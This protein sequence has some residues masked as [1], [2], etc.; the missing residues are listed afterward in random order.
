M[1]RSNLCTVQA[2]RRSPLGRIARVL[3]CAAMCAVLTV[4]CGG[5]STPLE[6]L[7]AEGDDSVIEGSEGG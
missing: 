4:G 3:T 2:W 6:D 7:P 5:E 1:E